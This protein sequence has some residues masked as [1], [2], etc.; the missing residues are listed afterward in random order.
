M[1]SKRSITI[2]IVG[3]ICLV[4]AI[5]IFGF[6]LYLLPYTLFNFNYNVPDFIVNLK[7]WLQEH[8]GVY[9][10]WQM[11]IL[12]LPPVTAGFLFLYLARE[13]SFSADEMEHIAE[14]S[15]PTPVIESEVLTNVELGPTDSAGDFQSYVKTTNPSIA[16]KKAGRVRR[17]HTLLKV[18]IYILLILLLLIMAEYFLV[19]G[20]EG[21][22]LSLD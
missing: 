16:I 8:H 17:H 14:P 13:F 6:I 18:M 19:T 7:T 3:I 9:G 21:R 15:P 12:L 20:F 2:Y 11:I 10:Y 4:V 22:W 1:V 5:G